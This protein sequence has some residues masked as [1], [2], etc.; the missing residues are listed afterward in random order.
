M[1]PTIL[2]TPSTPFDLEARNKSPIPKMNLDVDMNESRRESVSSFTSERSRSKSRSNC[3]AYSASVESGLET[4]K[5]QNGAYLF[6]PMKWLSETAG[7]LFDKRESIDFSNTYTQELLK[8]LFVYMSALGLDHTFS[9]NH[10]IFHKLYNVAV[11]LLLIASTLRKFTQIGDR[12]AQQKEI[13]LKDAMFDP[14]VVMT[15]CHCLFMFSGCSAAFMLLLFQQRRRRVYE[16]LDQ[17]IGKG[18]AKEEDAHL[19]NINKALVILSGVFS[20]IMATMH[21]FTKTGVLELPQS[22]PL[23]TN[24]LPF[25]I[26]ETYIIFVTQSSILMLAS[27]FSQ[28]CLILCSSIRRL[29]AEMLPVHEECPT[30]EQ[31]LKQIHDVQIHYQEL[32]N[33]KALI[34]E[35]FSFA[36]FFTYGCCIP[37]I[38]FLSY[39]LLKNS[40][41]S[42]TT[43][44]V[45]LL[46]WVFNTITVL[47]FFSIPAF[48]VQEEGEKILSSCFRM[49]HE[50]LCED[51]DLLV[52]SQMQFLSIQMH[53]SRIQLTAGNFFVMTRKILLTL[54]SAIFTYFLIIVQFESESKANN[55]KP[56]AKG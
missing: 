22:P 38:C 21:F 3:S 9:L 17:G 55:P 34:E 40:H 24:D 50:T 29:C 45:S 18:K 39:I 33:A 42:D 52:M 5:K 12:G 15:L 30:T 37:M 13:A 46:M 32:Y 6:G 26:M 8:P 44:T 54:I 1:E 56:P 25:I 14:S 47:L 23:I 19:L 10:S 4:A 48:M 35:N 16:V 31:S 43:E 27:L 11:F 36:I 51:R 7:Q 49:Y 53:T 41:L 28:L 2:V 20:S